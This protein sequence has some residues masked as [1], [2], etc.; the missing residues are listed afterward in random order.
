MRGSMRG[1]RGRAPRRRVA[2]CALGALV[3]LAG[4]AGPSGSRRGEPVRQA[5]GQGATPDGQAPRWSLEPTS[6]GKLDEIER[7]LDGPESRGAS[8]YW[9]VEARLQ[10]A[11][12]RLAFAGPER[13]RNTNPDTLR[14]R[15]TAAAE[16]FAEIL[17]APE[18]A[19][20]DQLARARRGARS[21]GDLGPTAAMPA[22]GP[23]NLT[24]L[25]KRSSWRASPANPGNLTPSA[26]R[27]RWITVHHSVFTPD[28][29][30]LD[31]SLDTVQRIQ[32]VHMDNE[33]YGDIGYHYLIDRQGRVIEGRS[34]R[35]QGAHAGDSSSNRGNVGICLLGNFE[36]EKP[37]AAAI[38]SLERLIVEL[39]RELRIPRRNVRPHSDWKE[40]LCPGR[41]LLPWF[42]RFD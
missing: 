38:R 6:W 3:L 24:G 29:S 20:P 8:A 15:R 18:A 31:A 22:S 14:Y 34:I 26:P 2:A 10:L 17:A 41:H 4:C 32:R 7:W 1:I 30:S 25:V 12:G 39:Q 33:G 37:T 40:T 13:D 42:A 35:W 9:R 23:T 27:W 21:I 36:V 19:T 16:A 28:D 11:E 5:P